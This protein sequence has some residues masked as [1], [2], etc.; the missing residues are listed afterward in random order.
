MAFVIRTV[1]RSAAGR[2]I[3][4]ERRIERDAITVGRD[5]GSD[6]HLPD[7][8]ITRHHAVIRLAATGRVLVEAGDNLPVDVDGLFTQHATIDL[9]RGGEIVLGAF[10]LLIGAGDTPGDVTILVERMPAHATERRDGRNRFSLAGVAPGKRRIAWLLAV[11]I[12]AAFLVWPIWS[13]YGSAH[14]RLSPQQIAGASAD[15]H[16]DAA[17]SPGKLSRAHAGLGGHC[18]ACH[19]KAFVAVTDDTCRSC[20][21]TVHD[22][23]DSAR[24]AAAR[25]PPDAGARLRLTIARVFGRP[26]GRCAD[27]HQEHLGAV[28]MA[29]T[30]Q[31]FCSDCHADL[32]ARLPDTRLENAAD[33]GTAH[34]EFRPTLLLR[35]GADALHARVSLAVNPK[36]DTGLKF[37]HAQHLAT[38]NGVARM[39]Q[40]LGQA[41]KGR[42]LQCASCHV[43]DAEGGFRAVS[44]EAN[45]QSCH[46]LAF[47]RADGM[48]RRL[49]HGNPEQAVGALQ[50]FYAAHGV[51]RPA[52]VNVASRRIPGDFAAASARALYGEAVADRG[53]A[54]DRAVRALFAPGG[55]C[56]DCH[57]IIPPPRARSLAFGIAPVTIPIRYLARSVFDHRTHAAESCASCHA[58]ARSNDARDVILP[59]IAECRGCHAG[60][61]TA[62]RGQVPS[63]CALCHGFH[64]SAPGPDDAPIRRR[65]AAI[66]RKPRDG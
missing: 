27:C 20:H 9:A 33:F 53:G 28:A 59:R 42:G 1:S 34:P 50:D 51:A 26:D 41:P 16:A 58:A 61:K 5:T 11:A 15:P 56:A 7:L 43:L 40:T 4:R 66:I 31:R 64:Q 45:C 47:G 30:P 23:A 37:T 35:P 25:S 6:I 36:Q 55:A 65:S 38:G 46:S 21:A 10:R 3:A 44:M 13:F 49:P 2:D 63:S 62:H 60:E 8:A 12:L 29:P 52:A 32:K 39:A 24:L 19:R 18:V 17:W 48:V 14:A 22:H 54:T 57:R